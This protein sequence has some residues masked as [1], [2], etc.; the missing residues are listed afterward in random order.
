MTGSTKNLRQTN[1]IHETALGAV[2]NSTMNKNLALLGVANASRVEKSVI[3]VLFAEA[4]SGTTAEIKKR[5]LVEKEIS[6]K[7]KHSKF[8]T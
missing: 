4:S 2:V 1:S 8:L 6:M 3:G 5:T 7:F